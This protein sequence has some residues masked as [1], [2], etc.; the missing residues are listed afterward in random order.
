MRAEKPPHAIRHSAC[1]H[2]CPS[3]CALEMGRL[4][5][6]RIGKVRGGAVFHDTALRL[7]K[8][9]ADATSALSRPLKN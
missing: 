5:D 1:P 9:P 2:D 4:D 6:L 7:R 3:T 8:A